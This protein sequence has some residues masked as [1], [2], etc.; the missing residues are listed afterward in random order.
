M[1][2]DLNGICDLLPFMKWRGVAIPVVPRSAS[3]NVYG[4]GVGSKRFLIFYATL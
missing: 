1:D 4:L 3:L 2:G